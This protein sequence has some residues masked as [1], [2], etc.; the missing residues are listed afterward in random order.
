VGAI[1]GEAG[2]RGSEIGAI[3]IGDRFS[4]V[5][6]AEEVADAVIDAMRGSKLKGRKVT[7]RRDRGT[8][9]D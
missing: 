2:I 1:T 6:V 8:E 5:E 9:R 3:Q 7:V 4:I